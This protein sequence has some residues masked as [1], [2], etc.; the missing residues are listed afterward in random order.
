MANNSKEQVIFSVLQHFGDVGVK[1]THERES[2]LYFAM[3]HFKN[4][5][6]K[7]KWDEA[8]KYLSG[9]TKVEDSDH[10]IKIYFELRKQKY[11]ET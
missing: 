7:G 6:L 3:E 11:L 8:E 9:F 5:I 4:M 1:E 10:S 2:G